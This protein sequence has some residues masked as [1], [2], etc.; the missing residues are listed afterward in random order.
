MGL[1]ADAAV[2]KETPVSRVVTLITELKAKVES[3]GRKEQQSYDK[4]ACWCE[5]TL[6]RKAAAI[7]EGKDNIEKLQTLI[8]KLNGDLGAHSAE[9]DQLKKDIADNLAA[10]KEATELRNKK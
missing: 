2:L 3:D 5:N 6:A 9:I 7:T 8:E 10:Q 4:Y 1:Q